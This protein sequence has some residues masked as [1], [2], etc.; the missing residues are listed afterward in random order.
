MRQVRFGVVAALV[1]LLLVLAACSSSAPQEDEMLWVTDHGA[2]IDGFSAGQRTSSGS[3]APAVALA[4]SDRPDGL[5]LDAQGDVW[6]GVTGTH[7]VV[8]YTPAQQ[9]SGGT[10]TP[11]VTIGSDGTS[12]RDP[13]SLAFDAHGNLWVGNAGNSTDI[14]MYRP[15][16]LVSSG[17]PTPSVSITGSYKTIVSLAFDANGDLWFT[18]TSDNRVAELTPSQLASSGSPTPHTTLS[19]SVLNEPVGLAFDASGDLWVA[20]FSSATSP[21]LMFTATQVKAGGT[22]SPTVVISDDGSGNLSGPLCLAFD[23]QG[24]LWVVGYGGPGG[25]D[26]V[27]FAAADIATSGKPAASVVLSGFTNINF[28]Q[29]AFGPALKQP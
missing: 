27:E 24:A 18:D 4:S 16:Q 3:P 29:L 10:P 28:P 8:E 12:L 2:G 20:N 21:L 22:P 17:S 14:E 1:L 23:G 7:G 15:S 11:S 19:S 6:V 26:L 13:V 5:A 9:A 25:Q